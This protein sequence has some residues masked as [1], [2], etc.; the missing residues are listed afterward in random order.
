MTNAIAVDASS[1]WQYSCALIQDGTV[2]CWG[3]NG[4]AG[5]GDNTTIP[6]A[7]APVEVCETGAWAVATNGCLDGQAVSTLG[8]VTAI[9]VGGDH[10]CALNTAGGVKCWGLNSLGEL[11]DGFA[12]GSLLCRTPTQVTGLTSGVVAISAGLSHTCA[13]VE[14][15]PPATGYGATCWG[16]SHFGQ[17]GDGHACGTHICPTPVQVTGLESGV[18][19]ISAGSLHTCAVLVAAGELQCWGLNAGGQLGDGTTAL[20]RTTPVNVCP[21]G[22][23]PPCLV[24]LQGASNVAAGGFF[25]TCAAFAPGGGVKC[26]GAN[27][28]GQ[29]GDGTTTPSLLPVDVCAAGAQAPCGAT[30]L[31]DASAAAV[32]NFHSCALLVDGTATCWGA[33]DAGQLGDG[34]P[35]PASSTPV[36]VCDAAG[37]SGCTALNE[38]Q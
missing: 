27:G 13:L 38:I 1:G 21:T 17:L 12:C 14:V 5:L 33:N 34:L 3:D 6:Y 10:A 19:Q 16:Y 11:G 2:R 7:R 8:N 24:A 31:S 26:W 28:S 23:V 36:T 20:L 9:A 18:A 32:G 25:H 37:G 15:E 22:A 35:G 30:I 29:L 4:K